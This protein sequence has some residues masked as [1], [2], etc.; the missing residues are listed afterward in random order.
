MKYVIKNKAL[1][2]FELV[3]NAAD[4]IAAYGVGRKIHV[5]VENGL[6]TATFTDLSP[7][8]GN[9]DRKEL[10]EAIRNTC[11]AYGKF[12]HF[13]GGAFG[14]TINGEMISIASNFS[15]AEILVLMKDGDTLRKDCGGMNFIALN[16]NYPGKANIGFVCIE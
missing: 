3:S 5:D 12:N 4:A 11:M 2:P 16:G 1:T 9:L 7:Y 13:P 10:E 8:M 14:F 6:L 15:L